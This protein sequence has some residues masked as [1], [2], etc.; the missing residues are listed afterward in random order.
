MGAAMNLLPVR[1]VP[2]TSALP[3]G[4]LLG[5]LRGLVGGDPAA[6]F[7]GAVGAD[8]FVITAMREFRSTL[9]PLVRGRLVAKAGGGTGVV[10]RLRPSGTVVVF[11]G[12][13][14]AFLAAFA[15]LVAVAHAREDGRSLL[16]LLAPAGLGAGSWLVMTATFSADARWAVEHLLER[17]PELVHPVEHLW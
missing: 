4:E 13:W 17:I 12:I 1:S 11:M 3:P 5:L 6:P 9:M 15:A 10:L 16:W 2:L 14:L 7:C 8:G